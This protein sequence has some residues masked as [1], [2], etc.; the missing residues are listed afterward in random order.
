MVDRGVLGT[1]RYRSRDGDGRPFFGSGPESSASIIA[2]C[3]GST[4]VT[5]ASVPLRLDGQDRAS[6]LPSDCDHVK[7]LLQPS[8]VLYRIDF[9]ADVGY[10]PRPASPRFEAE[11]VTPEPYGCL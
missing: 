11:S 6:L 5:P 1:L 3:F 4:A 2:S 10:A 7:A 8:I 9:L